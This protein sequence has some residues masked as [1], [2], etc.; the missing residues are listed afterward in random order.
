MCNRG[1]PGPT[2]EWLMKIQTPSQIGTTCMDCHGHEKKPKEHGKSVLPAR[3]QTQLKILPGDKSLQPMARRPL[4]N[5]S[6][7]ASNPVQS[8]QPDSDYTDTFSRFGLTISIHS[9]DLGHTLQALQDLIC[10]LSV[11]A[12]HMAS[13][14]G[15][16]F[17]V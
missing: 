2:R 6:C 17:A 3:L 14:N 10:L 7:W 16:T 9:T 8:I 5:R 4:T 12:K 11:F 13:D 1:P 15:P